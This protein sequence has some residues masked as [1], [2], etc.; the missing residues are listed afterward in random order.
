[1][2]HATDLTT[3][4]DNVL[5]DELMTTVQELM[6]EYSDADILVTQAL[7]DLMAA[8]EDY[9]RS[10]DSLYTLLRTPLRVV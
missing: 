4:D 7:Q 10:T 3:Q 1:M 5:A 8:V 2:N 6:V 9:K